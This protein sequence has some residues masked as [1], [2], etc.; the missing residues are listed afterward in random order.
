MQGIKTSTPAPF[1]HEGGGL[2]RPGVVPFRKDR[3]SKIG[4]I[5]VN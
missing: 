3:Q 4:I 5:N 2:A 1:A